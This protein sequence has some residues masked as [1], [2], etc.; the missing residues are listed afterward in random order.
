[1]AATATGYTLHFDFINSWK[2]AKELI[3]IAHHNGA[4]ILNVVPPAHIWNLPASKKILQN[5]FGLTKQLHMRI[6]LSR[7]DACPQ[8]TDDPHRTNYLFGQILDSPGIF[9]GGEQTNA[10]FKETVGLHSYEK[11]LRDE[12]EYYSK[13][14][15]NQENLVGFSVGIFNE[16]FVSQRGS[17]LSYDFITDSY[18]IAQYTPSCLH[19]WQTWL[20][21]KYGTLKMVNKRYH[22]SFSAFSLIPMPKNEDDKRFAKS[23]MAYCDLV[24]SINDWVKVQYQDCR[25]IWN[26]NAHRRIPLILQFSG[27]VPEKFSKGRPA[28]ALLDIYSWIEMADAV[29]ISLYTNN[30]YDDWGHDSDTAMVNFLYLAVLQ[31]KSIFVMEGG[32]ERNGAVL[33]PKELDFFGSVGRILKPESYI[34]EFL[35]APY[36][37]HFHNTDGYIV[38]ST[39]AINYHALTAVKNELSTS[40]QSA[41]ISHA[42]YVLDDPQ[43]LSL[44][45]DDLEIQQQLQVIA[46]KKALIFVPKD[47]VSLLPSGCSLLI[48]KKVYKE[49][50][51]KQLLPKHIK[52]IAARQWIHEGL[53]Q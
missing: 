33:V 14:Y 32:N 52:L 37:A 35:K 40:K 5:I 45:N 17:I 50:E 34:Y 15:S 6:V 42:V 44:D 28:F 26:K 36:Y 49:D 7:I 1:M 48:I 29:G 39:G 24:A 27:Y 23:A 13:N 47:S 11:W 20:K 31:N 19:W 22:S 51:Y 41:Y 10:F 9:P 12:T 18:E 8:S 25:D 3:L 4:E 2:Q 46:L 53:L 16:P 38:S 43:S 21:N 30:E